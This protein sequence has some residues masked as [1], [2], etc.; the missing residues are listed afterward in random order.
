MK[1]LK[2]FLLTAGA[3]V[4][5]SS[6]FASIEIWTSY[7]GDIGN[8]ADDTSDGAVSCGYHVGTHEVKNR[9]YVDFLNATGSTNAY[10][11]Y[12]SNMG[13]DTHGG[14]NQ[15][16]TSGGFAYSM[17][18]GFGNKPMDYLIFWDAARFTNYLT[19][20]LTNGLTT[21]GTENGVYDFA[22]QR[23]TVA[24]NVL[25]VALASEDELYEAVYYEGGRTT[26]GYWQYPTASNRITTDYANYGNNVAVRTLTNV[27]TSSA[28]PSYYRTFDQ[29]GN[30][31]D[32][33]DTIV[34]SST[35]GL[36]GALLYSTTTRSPR[37]GSTSIRRTRTAASVPVYPALPHS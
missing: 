22:V 33:N 2:I 24:W 15:S 11:V 31:L 1:Y 23:N 10:G 7:A 27:G 30:A 6:A 36:R 19:N 13:S 37:S 29:G 21:G 18:T 5:A 8:A 12:N 35:R 26:A 25:G 20:R 9:Q 16:G 17:K 14:I 34:G 32:W 4:S 28:D 3:L